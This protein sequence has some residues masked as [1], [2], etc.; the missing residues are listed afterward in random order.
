MSILHVY[1]A[2]PCCMSMLH[3]HDTC[4]CCMSMLLF[5]STCPCCMSVRHGHASCPRYLCCMSVL[6]IYAE[7]YNLYLFFCTILHSV[8]YKFYCT[9]VPHNVHFND[10]PITYVYS[11]TKQRSPSLKKKLPL[12]GSMDFPPRGILVSLLEVPSIPLGKLFAHPPPPPQ[13]THPH[14][15]YSPQFIPKYLCS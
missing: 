14:H 1:T 5:L 7:R 12:D 15:I 4:P 3:V 10:H 13:Y 2:C 6:H 9:I 11:L 8:C